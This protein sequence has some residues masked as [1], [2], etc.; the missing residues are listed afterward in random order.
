MDT[1]DFFYDPSPG[2]DGVVF[3]EEELAMAGDRFPFL[4][5]HCPSLMGRKFD[6]SWV[7]WL[8]SAF[9]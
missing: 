3:I 5:Q 1:V 2:S 9:G 8:G 6:L 4:L 7:K